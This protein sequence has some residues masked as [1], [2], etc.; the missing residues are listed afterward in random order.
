MMPAALQDLYRQ[1]IDCL[2]ARQWD[3][4]HRFV[5][6]DVVHNGRKLGVEGYRAMLVDDCERIPD[7]RFNVAL[8]ASTPPVLAAR[9]D[10]ECTPKGSFMG[11]AVN[12]RRV[13]FSENVFYRWGTNGRISEVWSVIDKAAIEVQLSRDDEAS[14]GT[15]SGAKI[16]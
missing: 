4:L 8:V 2:N 12:G 1:Y 14:A 6:D 9:I 13:A 15:T 10:F 5:D 11:L 16:S 7:L 3:G